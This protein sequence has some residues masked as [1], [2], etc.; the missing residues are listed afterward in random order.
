M[1]FKRAPSEQCLQ[2]SLLVLVRPKCHDCVHY[3]YSTA[4]LHTLAAFADGLVSV[5][6]VCEVLALLDMSCDK[7]QISK[8][9]CDSQE[10]QGGKLSADSAVK[11]PSLQLCLVAS[12]YCCTA[13]E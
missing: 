11:V 7:L 9:L 1:R 10:M 8:M 12:G 13:L 5:Q 4:E 6:E 3:R 2:S